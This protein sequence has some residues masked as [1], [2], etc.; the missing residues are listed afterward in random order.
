[1]G[2][3]RL[4]KRQVPDLGTLAQNLSGSGQKAVSNIYIYLDL[5]LRL[6]Q[7]KK[8]LVL[9]D[10]NQQSGLKIFIHQSKRRF[11]QTRN[12]QY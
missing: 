4:L 7:A 10:I 6:N 3:R 5:I 12:R 1:L 9:P 11:T 8:R 2:E